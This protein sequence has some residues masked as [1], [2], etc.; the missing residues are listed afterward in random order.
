MTSSHIKPPPQCIK[1]ELSTPVSLGVSIFL[2]FFVLNTAGSYS[3]ME[4]EIYLYT[5]R[6]ESNSVDLNVITPCEVTDHHCKKGIIHDK[7]SNVLK[8]INKFVNRKEICR[9]LLPQVYIK[10]H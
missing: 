1:L 10:F 6:T 2:C 7:C 5:S 9:F 8:Y 4:T 3:N